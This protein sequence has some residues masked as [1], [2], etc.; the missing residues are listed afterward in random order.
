MPSRVALALAR[1]PDPATG[2]RTGWT[3]CR[4]PD[5]GTGD[6]GVP[7]SRLPAGPPVVW[8]DPQNLSVATRPPQNDYNPVRGAKFRQSLPDVFEP[9]GGCMECP[10]RPT[11]GGIASQD[12]PSSSAPGFPTRAFR[13]RALGSPDDA[14]PLS[15]VAQARRAG[16][17]HDGSC[18]GLCVRPWGSNPS[19]A[20]KTRLTARAALHPD[21]A[22]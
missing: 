6:R 11:Q 2:S 5:L 22:A 18:A 16:R 9:T 7:G 19:A 4:R 17:Q 21:L 12:Q 15:G 1:H 8:G 10:K 13:A 20:S 3:V 14:F